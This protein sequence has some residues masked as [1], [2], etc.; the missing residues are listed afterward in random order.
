[1]WEFGSIISIVKNPKGWEEVIMHLKEGCLCSLLSFLKDLGSGILRA[2]L[3]VL[4]S[5]VWAHFEQ[6]CGE[7]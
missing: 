1:M 6:R 2:W 7:F 4:V 3:R 5:T